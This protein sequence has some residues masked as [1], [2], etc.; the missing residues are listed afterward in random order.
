MNFSSYVVFFYY[1]FF[2]LSGSWT[3]LFWD[4]MTISQPYPPPH[5]TRSIP[6]DVASPAQS[7]PARW[8]PPTL[9]RPPRRTTAPATSQIHPGVTVRPGSR[10]K[11]RL[12]LIPWTAGRL[13]PVL[14]TRLF[15]P[16]RW[17]LFLVFFLF[18]GG[19]GGGIDPQ[20]HFSK[21]EL[22]KQYCVLFPCAV[23]HK[24][25]TETLMTV[26]CLW[27][28]ISNQTYKNFNE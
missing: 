20:K 3:T 17:P 4:H 25:S 16:S 7:R 11:A 22:L 8:N 14:H 13:R 27:L 15:C 6:Q 18:G 12:V 24:D 21:P 28:D 1:F 26:G 2:F 23:L 19:G 5:P 10:D 9:P